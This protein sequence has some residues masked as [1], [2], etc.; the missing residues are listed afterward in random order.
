MSQAPPRLRRRLGGHGS[1]ALRARAAEE[2]FLRVQRAV[3]HNAAR[4]ATRGSLGGPALEYDE[5]VSDGYLEIDERRHPVVVLTFHGVFSDA[6]F[7]DYLDRLTEIAR[8][9]GVRALVY[10]IRASGVVPASQRRKMA[11]WM[12]RYQ[13]L[14]VTG[15]AGMAFVVESAIVRGIL[16]AILWM[17]PMACP[18]TVVADLETGIRWCEETLRKRAEAAAPTR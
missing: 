11:E 6:T 7:D 18:H 12:K 14:T 1:D 15:T 13:L 5:G 9:P 17:Q 10:D 4:L 2:G 3:Q 8:R 16:T